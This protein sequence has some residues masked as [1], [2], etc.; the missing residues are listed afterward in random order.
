MISKEGRLT[1]FYRATRS[2]ASVANSETSKREI[3]QANTKK[4]RLTIIQQQ[5]KAAAPIDPINS[6]RHLLPSYFCFY[7]SKKSSPSVM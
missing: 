5:P 4:L 3:Q 2:C 6:F 1:S 7:I